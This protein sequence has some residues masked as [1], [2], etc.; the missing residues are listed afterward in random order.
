MKEQRNVNYLL[1]SRQ[2]KKKKKISKRNKQIEQKQTKNNLKLQVNI[3]IKLSQFSGIDRR[4]SVG[5][6]LL[7]SRNITGG[8]NNSP[9]NS[10]LL[11]PNQSDKLLVPQKLKL[12]NQ[13]SQNNSPNHQRIASNNLQLGQSIYSNDE[14]MKNQSPTSN[15]GCINNQFSLLSQLSPKNANQN[16][17]AINANQ[18]NSPNLNLQKMSSG[19]NDCGS[20]GNQAIN[21]NS[22]SNNNG[23]NNNN[24]N[25]NNNSN[26]NNNCSGNNSSGKANTLSNYTTYIPYDKMLQGMEEEDILDTDGGI[27]F[28]RVIDKQY[29]IRY[30]QMMKIVKSDQE[31]QNMLDQIQMYQSIKHEGII[32]IKKWSCE[33][34]L[35][36]NMKR[37]HKFL[38]IFDGISER[39]DQ[40]YPNNGKKTLL[41]AFKNDDFRNFVNII[42]AVQYL[43]SIKDPNFTIS[44]LLPCNFA[45]SYDNT[46]K[47][48]PQPFL[49]TPKIKERMKEYENMYAPPEIVKNFKFYNQEKASIFY[50]GMN[51]LLML[52]NEIKKEANTSLIEQQRLLEFIK[53]TYCTD[54]KNVIEKMIALDPNDRYSFSQIVAYIRK[55]SIYTSIET[56]VADTFTNSD[57]Y[58]FFAHSGF[59]Q[60]QQPKYKF[61]ATVFPF[62]KRLVQSNLFDEKRIFIEQLDLDVDILIPDDTAVLTGDNYEVWLIGGKQSNA[63]YLLNDEVP[64]L[65]PLAQI[66]CQYQRYGFGYCNFSSQ[67]IFLV[68]G[69]VDSDTRLTTRVDRYDVA[70]NE[71][72]QMEN[73]IFAANGSTIVV[74]NN[75]TIYKFGGKNDEG[76]IIDQLEKYDIQN[77]KWEIQ[78]F[79]IQKGSEDIAFFKSLAIQINPCQI[80]ICGGFVFNKETKN[81][82]PNYNFHFLNIDD[83]AVNID[84]ARKQT[85][86]EFSKA[87]KIVFPK[88]KQK[89]QEED[90]QNKYDYNY[91]KLKQQQLREIQIDCLV[92]A[93]NSIWFVQAKN[94][95]SKVL[96]KYNHQQNVTE[97]KKINY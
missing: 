5:N 43:S 91:I 9:R 58:D 69:Y 24:N 21:P 19:N 67:Y 80:L 79:R 76:Q 4:E 16:G 20:S 55:Q 95:M 12:T 8:S 66:P 29:H 39:L 6:N 33:L 48:I 90:I 42:Q 60:I 81:R 94:K 22:S 13:H 49:I 27:V 17:V 50:I 28:Q 87:P 46:F 36:K 70:T 96:Y 61:I 93:Q 62:T 18:L 64:T 10:P 84:K 78:S 82:E 73:C 23:S 26:N 59:I 41:S 57:D 88:S 7:L 97:F 77:N 71:W 3:F 54:L 85:Y 34:F 86:A 40:R 63:I 35:D 83:K 45:F 37:S 15:S 72:K 89:E 68:S 11:N 44:P 2:L 56:I 52:T 92:M 51:L 14:A 38:I 30:T 75:N 32:S 25:N 74:F 1:A 31:Y 47:F 65:T 53:K